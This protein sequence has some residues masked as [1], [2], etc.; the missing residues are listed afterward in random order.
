LKFV[1]Q[2]FAK[3]GLRQRRRIAEE[4][5]FELVNLYIRNKTK[6][7]PQVRDLTRDFPMQRLFDIADSFLAN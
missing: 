1:S 2:V 6:V 4:E 5:P 7:G 3:H